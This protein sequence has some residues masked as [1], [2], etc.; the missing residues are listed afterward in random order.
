MQL[1][2]SC[3]ILILLGLPGFLRAPAQSSI[4][5]AQ[6]TFRLCAVY[7]RH[8]GPELS[9]GASCHGPSA[10]VFLRPLHVLS[11]A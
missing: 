9:E 6:G 4:P 10:G 11:R 3:L 5:Q 7:K 1:A 8:A 2:C